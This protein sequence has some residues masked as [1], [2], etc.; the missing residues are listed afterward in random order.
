MYSDRKVELETFVK[1]WNRNWHVYFMECRIDSPGKVRGV[2][3]KSHS[4]VEN[5][6]CLNLLRSQEQY[7]LGKQGVAPRKS[8]NGKKAIFS[9]ALTG[10]SYE[11]IYKRFSKLRKRDLR[12]GCIH[13]S[14]LSIDNAQS[15]LDVLSSSI[16]KDLHYEFF[17]SFP[18]PELPV[19]L[20][21]TFVSKGLL[22]M[23]VFTDKCTDRLIGVTYSCMV[24]DE[25]CVPFFIYQRS[26]PIPR[27]ISTFMW[28]YHIQ[29][30]ISS[31]ASILNLGTSELGSNVA[32]YKRS[33]GAGYTIKYTC[34]PEHKWLGNTLRIG[35]IGRLFLKL[36][37]RYFS[38]MVGYF[39]YKFFGKLI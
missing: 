25:Y 28:D 24:E 31:K 16:Y 1:S 5:A 37:P 20:L 10:V 18:S 27:G 15:P 11:D 19:G 29:A 26:H 39:A 38:P 14:T 17:K 12:F 35:A 8:S 3:L 2:R 13:Y 9:M 7:Q 21:K 4:H 22:R 33:L 6:Y 36:L 34:L 23:T 32:N 30:A